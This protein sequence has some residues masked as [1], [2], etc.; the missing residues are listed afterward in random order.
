MVFGWLNNG[1]HGW[2][3]KV[4]CNLRLT[5]NTGYMV[6]AVADASGDARQWVNS[7]GFSASWTVALI[8]THGP[9]YLNLS[10]ITHP[11]STEAQAL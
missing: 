4:Y 11:S 1:T 5:H 2:L 7:R 8:A 10:S 3:I 9:L 6:L